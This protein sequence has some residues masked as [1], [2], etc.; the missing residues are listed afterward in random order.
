MPTEND[1]D[2]P[3]WPRIKEDTVPPAIDLTTDNNS[4]D[5]EDLEFAIDQRTEWE[6]GTGD[7]I[8]SRDSTSVTVPLEANRQSSTAIQSLNKS[9]QDKQEFVISKMLTQNAHGLRRRARD[10]GRNILP[11]SPFDYTRYKHLITTMKLKEIDVYFI[12]ETWLEGDMF[13]EMINGYHVFCHNGGVGHHSF[14][15]VAIVLS[16]RYYDGWKAAGA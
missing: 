6:D 5:E 9:K 7:N 15:G 16:P 8:N 11:N 1:R 2:G 10:N 12:Q 14:R 3:V 4:N 13:N